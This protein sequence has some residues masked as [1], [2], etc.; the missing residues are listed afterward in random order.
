MP[1]LLILLVLAAPISACEPADPNACDVQGATRCL[2]DGSGTERCRSDGLWSVVQTCDADQQCQVDADEVASCVTDTTLA[3]GELAATRCLDDLSGVERCRSD[4]QWSVVQTCNADQQ[5]EVSG[6]AASCV[7][8]TTLACGELGATRCLPDGSGTERCRSNGQWEVVQTCDPDQ[9]CQTS[10]HGAG[11]VTDTTLACGELGA[12]RCLADGSA[13][14]RCRSDGQWGTVQ[15]CV[16]TQTC[17][18]SDDGDAHCVSDDTL[19]CGDLG[20]TRCLPDGS[21]TER[22]R[23]DGAWAVVQWCGVDQACELGASGSSCVTD[24]TLGCGELG[25]TRCL[26]DGSGVERCRSDGAW[27]VVQ[28]CT[29]TQRCESND[30]GSGCVTQ[31]AAGCGALGATRCLEDGTGV[32]RCRSDGAW[33]VVQFCTAAEVCEVSGASSTATCGD[34]GLGPVWPAPTITDAASPWYERGCPLVQQIAHPSA[35][36]ADCRCF[37]N[38]APVNGIPL[39]HRPYHAALDGTSVGAGPTFA[40]VYNAEYLGG[41]L[42][43]AA[44][45]DGLVFV[46]VGYGPSTARLGAILKVDL[47]TGDRTLVSGSHPFAG[48]VGSGPD[49]GTVL[50]VQ[51]APG[52]Q[53][54]AFVRTTPPAEQEIYRVDPTSG[55]RTLMWRG[56]DA[57]YPQCAFQTTDSGFAVDDQGRVYLPFANPIVDGRGIYRLSADFSSCELVT[58]TAHPNGD[59]RGTGPALGGFVQGFTLEDGK[60]YAF[61]TQP[62]QFVAVDLATGNRTLLLNPGGIAPPERWARWDAGRSVWWLAG[63]NS[64]VSISAWDPAVNVEASVFAGG[65]FP[66]MPLGA[67]GPVQINALNYAPIWVRANGNLLI[68]QDGFSIVEVEPATGNSVILSL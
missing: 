28:S 16:G 38:Q 65:V 6:E 49:L 1:K 41:F 11:C 67:S 8:D 21:G 20:A 4:G 58:R 61:T 12:T 42:D 36:P 63:F 30:D 51:R 46:A 31:A 22:C 5:C 52:G 10:D 26:P 24:T 50:D 7:T 17:G 13:V 3:C 44:G 9:N 14:E 53:L 32:E 48:S 57:A 40:L 59:N 25:A 19:A 64:A 43:E 66:W 35:L 2:P 60:L 56:R 15:T 62:K 55:A 23:S 37:T 18:V 47:A 45:A 27:G 33:G 68:G 29:A 39:C 54:Y 34:A